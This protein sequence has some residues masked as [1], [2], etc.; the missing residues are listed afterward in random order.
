MCTTCLPTIQ[1][2]VCPATH[3]PRLPQAMYILPQ[4]HMYAPQPCMPLPSSH[5]PPA[6]HTSQLCMPHPP[7]MHTPSHAWTSNH[8]H[9][10][11]VTHTLSSAVQAPSPPQPHMSPLQSHTPHYPS[12][13]CPIPQPYMTPSPAIHL[14]PSPNRMSDACETIS[15]P[16]LR[17]RAVITCIVTNIVWK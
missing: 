13:A 5:A 8:A 3:T 10:L 16:Q 14:P 1:G 6:T 11:P 17:L 9:A 4:P 15:F 2:R 7:D 12:H